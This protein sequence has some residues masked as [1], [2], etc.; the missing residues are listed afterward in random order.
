MIFG[1]FMPGYATRKLDVHIGAFKGR[2]RALG[3]HMQYA[4]PD[5]HAERA[6]ICS[7][8]WSLFGQ[9]W[10][11]SKVLAKAVKDIRIKGRRILEVGCGLALPSL[12][13]QYRG[14]DI[15]ASDHHPLT[16][17]FLDHNARLN[18][19][20]LLPY[21]NL[22]W[23]TGGDGV[24]GFDLIVGSDVLYEPGHAQMLVGLI[25]RIAKPASKVLISCPGRGYRNKFSRSMQALGY[26][27]TETRVAFS[28]D[29]QPP[30][31]GRLLCYLR[32]A[33][34]RD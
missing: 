26:K 33:H 28:N 5:G 19:L 15:T 21:L 27:L 10:P 4:D 29:E 22:P 8:S 13:L 9:L 20:P 24:Q 1:V 18:G 2:L 25:E 16:E 23:G 7:A 30:F 31:K 32:E 6:G 14:A 11:A 34:G 12:V 3:D 17:S